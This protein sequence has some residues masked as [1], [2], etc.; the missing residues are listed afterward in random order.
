MTKETD[1]YKP[2]KH[3]LESRGFTVKGEV[4]NCDI[5]AMC[6]DELWI[7]EMKHNLSVKLLYQAMS[8]LALTP[9]VF[10]AIPRPKRADKNFRSAQ[11]VIKKLELGLIVVAL[12][13]EAPFA[14][15]VLTPGKAHRIYKKSAAIRKEIE[16]RIGDTPGGSSKTTITT[17][18]RERCIK[19]ACVLNKH[20]KPVSPRELIHEYKCG[21]GV[22][23]ILQR[24]Y[25]GWFERI[26]HGRYT[27]SDIGRDFLVKNFDNPVVRENQS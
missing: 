14:E 4:K 26:S 2:I 22:G 12:D 27:L 17:L 3:L 20:E 11:K 7:V 23:V 5:A 25:Y 24:N 21:K 10:V 1:M 15:I 8:R 13:S 19:I 18:Y 6:G 9:C 16:G